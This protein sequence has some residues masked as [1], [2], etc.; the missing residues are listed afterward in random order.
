MNRIFCIIITTIYFQLNASAQSKLGGGLKFGYYFNNSFMVEKLVNGTYIHST[1]DGL[2]GFKVDAFLD[3]P[4][5]N[6]FVLSGEF[7]HSWNIGMTGPIIQLENTTASS[8]PSTWLISTSPSFNTLEL[9][10]KLRFKLSRYVEPFVGLGILRLTNFERSSFTYLDEEEFDEELRE[11]VRRINYQNELVASVENCYRN[12]TLVNS[13]GV[14]FR[15]KR[16]LLDAIYERTITPVSKNLIF[17]DQSYS[18]V[19][20]MDRLSIMFGYKLF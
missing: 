5:T 9:H 3:F 6:R 17:R 14:R 2:D 11:E 19:Q 16:L 4:I 8:D 12:W 7:S 1:S 15:F 18:F 20:H 10:S 13:L